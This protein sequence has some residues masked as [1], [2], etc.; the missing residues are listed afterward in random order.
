MWLLLVFRHPQVY[1]AW[2]AYYQ[3]LCLG[4]QVPSNLVSLQNGPADSELEFRIKHGVPL[5]T[6]SVDSGLVFGWG[7]GWDGLAP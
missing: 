2:C 4:A 5:L 3:V 1:S 6:D 7:W